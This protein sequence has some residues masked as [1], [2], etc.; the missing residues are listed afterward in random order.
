MKFFV[1]ILIFSITQSCMAADISFVVYY[2]KGSVV[3]KSSGALLKKGDP[4]Y[5]HE[6]LSVGFQSNVILVC[7]NYKIIQISKKGN[8][9]VKNLLSQCNKNQTS[10]TSSYFEYVWNEFTHPH[11]KP[12]KDPEE[13][14]KNVGAASRGCNMVTTHIKLDTLNYAF[15]KLPVYWIA[16]HNKPYASVYNHPYDGGPL[17]K[18]LLIK[19]KPIQL[20]TLTKGLKPGEYY[21]QITEED[22]SGCERNFIKLWDRVVY[23]QALNRLLKSVPVTSYAETAYLKGFLMEENHFLA[24]ALKYYHLAVKFNPSNKIFK[25][26]LAKFYENNF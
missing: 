24:E 5:S 18:V 6:M 9:P 11:G 4:V 13:Y 14:M 10:Y 12:E 19:N 23:Q 1:F 15:G 26:S 25:K 17:V 21:W 22:G 2:S 20:E 3:K 16:S 7:S 8:Y